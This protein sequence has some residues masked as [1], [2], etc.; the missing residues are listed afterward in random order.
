MLSASVVKGDQALSFLDCRFP[1]LCSKRCWWLI[2]RKAT[3][4]YKAANLGQPR[5]PP[6]TLHSPGTTH[7]KG[8]HRS[9]A[10]A[11]GP[12][13]ALPGSVR[14]VAVGSAPAEIP[15]CHLAPCH[16]GSGDA[17]RAPEL[18]LVQ[19]WVISL[20]QAAPVQVLCQGCC[21][22]ETS[23]VGSVPLKN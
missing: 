10:G 11:A 23:E 7:P 20:C 12:H 2:R 6:H 19:R 18:R 17:D 3:F 5:F 15:E 21:G 13:L 8:L 1:S 9:Q 4:T 16:S 14:A 22:G